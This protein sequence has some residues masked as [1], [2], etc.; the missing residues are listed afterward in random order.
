MTFMECDVL[1]IVQV[2]PCQGLPIT[3]YKLLNALPIH[4]K[5]I[6]SLVAVNNGYTSSY[7]LIRIRY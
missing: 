3:Y 2:Q 5:H 7:A 6:L 1:L 4:T